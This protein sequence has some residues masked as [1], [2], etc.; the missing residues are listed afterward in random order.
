MKKQKPRIETKD[1]KVT[2]VINATEEELT[3]LILASLDQ[4]EE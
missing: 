2:V 3:T 4:K 1:L